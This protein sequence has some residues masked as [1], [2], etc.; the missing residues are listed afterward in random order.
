[1]QAVEGEID[2]EDFSARGRFSV[3][4]AAAASLLQ[5]EMSSSAS[6]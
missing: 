1:M 4:P 6:Y 3:Q 5:V 2:V